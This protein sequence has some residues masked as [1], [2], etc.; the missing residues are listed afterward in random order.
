VV[1]V[2]SYA[3]P[4]ES[5]LRHRRWTL[6]RPDGTLLELDA[7]PAPGAAQGSAGRAGAGR[8]RVCLAGYADRTAV[9]GL[10]GCE[11]LL[12]REQLPAAGEREYF[13]EDLLGF[14]VRTLSG[15]TL[16]HLAH[17][18]E[19]PSG[20]LMVVRGERERWVPAF[21]PWLRRVDLVSRLV[22]VD[23]PEDL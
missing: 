9:E 10:R 2:E 13:R 23:W 16:G 18:V 15:V 8:L 12:P 17:F 11:V 4:P 19:A 3:D 20:A 21:A 5:L 22:E 14:A 1:R 7:Q 6:R